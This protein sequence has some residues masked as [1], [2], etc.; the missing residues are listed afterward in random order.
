MPNFGKVTRKSERLQK[1]D[2][3]IQV[4]KMEMQEN[5][6]NVTENDESASNLSKEISSDMDMI[7]KNETTSEMSEEM[8][9]DLDI[10]S[11]SI[12]KE[13]EAA[14]DGYLPEKLIHH[15]FKQ[16]SNSIAYLHRNRWIH[17]E[18]KEELRRDSER[19]KGDWRN[20]LCGASLSKSLLV[21]STRLGR[22][23]DECN[24][25]TVRLLMMMLHDSDHSHITIDQPIST[26][27]N[28]MGCTRSFTRRF[29]YETHL[30]THYPKREKKYACDVGRTTSSATAKSHGVAAEPKGLCRAA[31]GGCGPRA[32]GCG[33]EG[34]WRWFLGNGKVKVELGKEEEEEDGEEQSGSDWTGDE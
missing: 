30:E 14:H 34:G 25:K 24:Y 16:L 10:H 4:T 29:N 11:D 15:I 8:H 12:V 31:A 27:V 5:V 2:N 22:G 32:T 1:V 18:L 19:A 3:E 23:Q 13:D 7:E 26:F 28:D 33:G 20:P 9:G 21:N 17:G 6:D